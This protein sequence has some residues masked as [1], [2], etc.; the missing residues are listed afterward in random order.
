MIKFFKNIMIMIVLL[1]TT[2]LSSYLIDVKLNTNKISDIT[3]IVFIGHSNIQ[4]SLND[5][6]ISKKLNAKCTNY[7][8]GGQ[9]LFWTVISAKKHKLQ[10]VNNFIISLDE[11]TYTTGDKTFN[12]SGSHNMSYYKNFLSL[13]DW[14]ALINMDLKFSLKSLFILPKPTL[15]FIG[16]FTKGKRPFYDGL[17]KF[18]RNKIINTDDKILHDFIKDNP[19]S[20]FV[21]IKSSF[22]P[23]YYKNEKYIKNVQHLANRLNTFRK[24]NNTLVLDCGH[25][26]KNDSLFM[27]H[28]HLNYKGAEILSNE[29]AEILIKTEFFKNQ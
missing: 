18:N 7:G 24:Y 29:V 9:S 11:V 13:N 28:N 5:S 4:H 3:D 10:G 12:R 1:C 16:N 19:T 23:N 2:C 20:N 14:L 27:D 26:L 25:F 21:I 22:H 8:A 15:N 6:L 17:T